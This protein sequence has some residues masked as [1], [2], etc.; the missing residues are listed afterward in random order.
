[1]KPSLLAL[2]FWMAFWFKLILAQCGKR[3][4]SRMYMHWLN[5]LLLQPWNVI[6]NFTNKLP[7]STLS[8]QAQL[9]GAKSG[10]RTGL[11]FI[12]FLVSWKQALLS[13]QADLSSSES[14][15]R[16]ENPFKR[17][18]EWSRSHRFFGM[19]SRRVKCLLGVLALVF[20]CAQCKFMSRKN[21]WRTTITCR[22][23]L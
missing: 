17:E 23:P 4:R 21:A 14:G 22:F 13:S 6:S 5:T 2:F 1:M 10:R 11:F 8:S 7:Q 12:L 19:K 16:P 15:T 9:K 18:S 3:R 20:L